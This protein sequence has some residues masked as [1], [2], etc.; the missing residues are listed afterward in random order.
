MRYFELT[1]HF[2]VFYSPLSVFA[3]RSPAYE[4]VYVSARV[5]SA[6]LPTA[7]TLP[8]PFTSFAGL[9]N[10]Y[11]T[12]YLYYVHVNCKVC[13]IQRVGMQIADAGIM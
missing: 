12:V 13:I 7:G 3:R 9:C 2:L 5:A 8:L 6:S 11:C 1:T 4:L 10:V